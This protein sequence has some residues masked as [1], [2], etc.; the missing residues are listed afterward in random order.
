MKGRK[1]AATGFDA[2]GCAQHV[3]LIRLHFLR[4]PLTRFG[5]KQARAA[6]PEL[7]LMQGNVQVNG[8]KMAAV[9]REPQLA[10]ARRSNIA[11]MCVWPFEDDPSRGISCH[12]IV[13]MRSQGQSRRRS[14]KLLPYQCLCV[15]DSLSCAGDCDFPIARALHKVLTVRDADLHIA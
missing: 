7:Q 3:A 11:I 12:E 9:A 6:G 8:S 2:H 1:G 5:P 15:A 14:S 4:A 10:Q 13:A